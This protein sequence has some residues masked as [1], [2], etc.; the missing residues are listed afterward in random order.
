LDSTEL[1]KIAAVLF[2]YGIAAPI[3]GLLLRKHPNRQ[4]WIVGLLCFVTTGG[5]L[6]PAD[7]GL[8]LS[9]FEYRGHAKG[10]HFYA[11]D[12]L[13]LALIIGRALDGW[14]DFRLL[15]P[16]LWFYLLYCAASLVSVINAPD[17]NLVYFAAFK[18]V[19]MA[20][21][22][23]AAYNFIQTEDHLRFFVLAMCVTMAWQF[24]VVLK[25]K[26]LEGVYQVPGT[27]E[28]Q[29]SLSMFTTMIAMV[30]L[31]AALGPKHPHSNWY[32]AAFFACAFIQVST[33]SRAGL[34]SFAVGTVAV[35]F[36]SLVDKL[37][38]R[39]WL[40]LGCLGFVGIIGSLKA[41]DTIKSRFEDESNASSIKTRELLNA[42]ARH[43]LDDYP[44][45]IGWNNFGLVIN[46]PFPYGDI[47]DRWE[48]EGGARVDETHQKGISESHY[49]LLLS[50]TGYQS[51]FFYL[52]FISAF[53][54][55]NIRAAFAYRYHFLGSISVGIAVGCG[56]NYLQSF[57]E[58]VLTQ[59]RNM[60]LWML[61]LGAT[62]RI[63]MWRRQA[64]RQNRDEML[65]E[66][67]YALQ[68]Q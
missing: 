34:A 46:K 6:T 62:A 19:K 2:C 54:W 15:P 47:I 26:Y 1:N 45:G 51:L 4:R 52:L 60:M 50:E 23:V 66:P 44:L 36:L 16:G 41:I 24:L 20:L 5:I 29:N 40:V 53:L 22:L 57:L 11:A 37:T 9:F 33:L 13:A 28:H 3:L 17:P 59:P 43:M 32:L 39:R 25:L 65:E 12:V 38:R 58:R 48:R 68:E 21:F 67:Q 42:A 8:T 7:W 55:R 31:A 64:R 63:E 18:Y 27:F 56:C 35:L 14:R 30:L 49:Y 61:L 10:Y